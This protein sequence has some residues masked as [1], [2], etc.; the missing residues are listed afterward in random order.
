MISFG[1]LEAP[2]NGYVIRC[3]MLAQKLVKDG[4][5]VT[6]YQFSN[7]DGVTSRDGIEIHSIRVSHEDQQE[8]RLEKII[9]FNPL[10]ELAFPFDGYMKLRQHKKEL[11]DYDEFYIESCMLMNAIAMVR[12]LHKPITI[13]THCM[14]KD[15]ALKLQRQNKFQGT[16]RT[17][18]WHV[19]ENSSLKRADKVIAI[20]DQDRQFM[21]KHY[22]VPD[23]RI[24]VIP[25]VV[26]AAA[27]DKYQKQADNL[28]QQYARNG[29]KVACFVGDLGAI[30]NVETEKFIRENLAPHTPNINYVLVGNNPKKLISKDN[31]VYTDF[32][33]SVDPYVMMADVC[34][35]PMSIGSGIKTKLLDYLKYNKPIIA[36]PVAIEGIDP[37]KDTKVCDREDFLQTLLEATEDR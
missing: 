14:N 10:R 27:A 17:A 3:W 28:K 25:H 36:T 33:E 8:S 7:K 34:I 5:K 4:N 35:A 15:V 1:N 16:I 26:D 18:I 6:V 30:Q 23:E 31:I 24:V 13:D 29:K 22:Q 37:S 21:M 12:S 19:I 32:V 2:R 11:L 20:S 9:G